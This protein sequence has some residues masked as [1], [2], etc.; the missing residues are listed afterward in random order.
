MTTILQSHWPSLVAL[1]A[2][3]NRTQYAMNAPTE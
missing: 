2:H 3:P 1:R